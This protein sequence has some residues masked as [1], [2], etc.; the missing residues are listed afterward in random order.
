MWVNRSLFTTICLTAL[1]HITPAADPLAQGRELTSALQQSTQ[2]NKRKEINS[3]LGRAR[4]LV[5]G[6]A[7]VNVRGAQ[8][9]TPLHWI[10]IGTSQFNNKK[11]HRAYRELAELLIDQQA[12]VNAE[13]DYGN[14]PLDWEEANPEESLRYVL[15]QAGARNGSSHSDANRM[16]AYLEE[17]RR[18]AKNKDLA[19]LTR[20]LDA[21][22]PAGAEIWV[23]I[24]EPIHTKRSRSGDPLTAVVIAPVRHEGRILLEAGTKV[25][26]TLLR[27]RSA[28]NR[29]TRAEAVI[30][31]TNFHHADGTISRIPTRVLDVDN[32]RET[33]NHGWILGVPFPNEVVGRWT[34]GLRGLGFVLPGVSEGLR[35]STEAYS[36]TL[37]REIDYP[38]GTELRLRVSVPGGLKTKARQKDWPEVK[39]DPELIQLVRAQPLRVKTPSNADSDIINL[40]FIGHPEDLEAGFREAG[41]QEAKSLGVTSGARTAFAALRK[42]G[43]Q[44]APFAR[45]QLDGKDPDYEYQKDLNTVAKRHH[46]RIYRR[47]E[48]YRG[49]PVWIASSTHDIGIGAGRFGTQWY[50]LI[51]PEIDKE[52]QKIADDLLFSGAATGYS[53]I[54]RANAPRKASN[55][56]GD[57][58]RTDGKMMVIHLTAGSP[59]KHAVQAAQR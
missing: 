58:L 46:L 15:E 33:V 24:T 26:G 13:D 54:D 20:I 49:Q 47:T 29:F 37:G 9:R 1:T 19:G 56:T 8:G 3:I 32:A 25:E 35:W 43:Y 5:V 50:H 48:T 27:A 23:R 36:R 30:D 18:L 39:P 17:L 34:M 52:R 40:T 59:R 7:D 10:A 14:T 45:L 6:G 38:A 21:D 57:E 31:L 22:L 12:N 2:E 55:A 51:D 28:R 41:W 42:Q 11:V 16:L 4:K 44:E 53:L